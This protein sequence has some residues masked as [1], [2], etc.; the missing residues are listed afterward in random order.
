MPHGNWLASSLYFTC[1]TTAKHYAPETVGSLFWSRAFFFFFLAE[2]SENITLICKGMCGGSPYWKRALRYSS[3][4]SFEVCTVTQGLCYLHVWREKIIF[5]EG[6]PNIEAPT[7]DQ[8]EPG[9]QKFTYFTWGYHVKGGNPSLTCHQSGGSFLVLS[10]TCF[11]AASRTPNHRQDP[12]G[13]LGTH[14]KTSLL[15]GLPAYV[16]QQR[17]QAGCWQGRCV[18]AAWCGREWSRCHCSLWA[19]VGFHAL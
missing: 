10:S 2:F 13:A 11:T 17:L 5:N 1:L 16:Q 8:A 3:L 9:E 14:D 19:V 6:P 7:A 15:E 4:V 18:E 12:H